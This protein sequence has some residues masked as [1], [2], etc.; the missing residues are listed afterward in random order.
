M[1]ITISA[2]TESALPV[3]I[4]PAEPEVQ[5]EDPGAFA[6][7]LAGLLRKTGTDI[8]ELTDTGQAESEVQSTEEPVSQEFLVYEIPAETE[9]PE[10]IPVSAA[11]AEEEDDDFVEAFQGVELLLYQYAEQPKIPETTEVSFTEGQAEVL[12]VEDI[13]VSEGVPVLPVDFSLQTEGLPPLTEAL[14]VKQ[15]DP[16]AEKTE[17]AA[18]AEGKRQNLPDTGI[19]LADT[20]EIPPPRDFVEEAPVQKAEAKQER[21]AEDK[22]K[23][24]DRVVFEVRDF[25]TEVQDAD[26]KPLRAASR[27]DAPN[28]EISLELRLTDGQSS[29]AQAEVKPSNSSPPEGASSALENLLARELHQNFNGDIVRHA[30]MAVR[31]GG[32]GTIRLSLKPESLGNVKI[33]LELAENKITGRIVVESEEA[34]RA[35][36]QE[37][38]S[39]ERAFRDSG[40]SGAELNLSLAADG[41][42]GQAPEE[43]QPA[44]LMRQA[45]FDYDSSADM[46][47]VTVY[48]RELNTINLLA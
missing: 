19:S 41:N 32:E 35:F 13:L 14:S 15:I 34:L 5:D 8:K 44:F 11:I 46:F 33:S 30:S 23:R 2:Y 20:G 29:S 28:R 38:S 18:V 4:T 40:F 27:Q 39:L 7:I 31:D 3:Q 26:Q 22:G 24:K 48:Q 45:A 6:K 47:L 43:K 9:S 1:V 25:R 21:F 10:E 36:K 42:D 37:I 17:K 16:G 12:P